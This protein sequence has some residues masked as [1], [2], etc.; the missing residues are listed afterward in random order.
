MRAASHRRLP[1]LLNK[2]WGL[3]ALC[4]L[5]SPMEAKSMLYGMMSTN[6]VGISSK[7]YHVTFIFEIF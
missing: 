1:L 7:F 5:G 4:V 3:M 6:N 2:V